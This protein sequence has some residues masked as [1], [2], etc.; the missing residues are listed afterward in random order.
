MRDARG[1]SFGPSTM[2]FDPPG[3]MRLLGPVL[4]SLDDTKRWEPDPTDFVPLNDVVEAYLAPLGVAPVREAMEM[5]RGR[6]GGASFNALLRT[7]SRF[8]EHQGNTMH[9]SWLD[10][11][12][13]LLADRDGADC[14]PSLLA[15]RLGHAIRSLVGYAC[16]ATLVADAL[17]Y[18]DDGFSVLHESVTLFALGGRLDLVPGSDLVP[19]GVMLDRLQG[20]IWWWPLSQEPK[21]PLPSMA[22]SP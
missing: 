8:H 9:R 17:L 5:Q 22:V 1:N 15:V 18:G 16:D 7:A 2:P 14:D 13:C 11:P 6:C 4:T 12:V 19:P 10:Y 21:G 3:V 20:P